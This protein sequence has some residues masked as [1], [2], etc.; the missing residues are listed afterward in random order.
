MSD[1]QKL[2]EVECTAQVRRLYH[3]LAASKAEAEDLICESGDEYLVHEEDIS[4]DVDGV[5]AAKEQP[6]K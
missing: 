6:S 5:K 2:Y 1:A 4:E 3:V